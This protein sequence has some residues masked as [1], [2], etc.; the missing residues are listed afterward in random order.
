LEKAIKNPIF[1]NLKP[2]MK[3]ISLRLPT[4]LLSMIKQIAKAK[5]V[6]YQSLMKIFLI[7]KIKEEY[8][9]F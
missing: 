3:T 7:D 6:P 1:P 4:F 8:H 5:D 9:S 2:S